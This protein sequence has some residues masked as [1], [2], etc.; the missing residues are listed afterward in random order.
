MTDLNE[1][2]STYHEGVSLTEQGKYTKALSLCNKVIKKEP[3]N[4]GALCTKSFVLF[5]L[6]KKQ[7]AKLFYEKALLTYPN[8]V[9]NFSI[10]DEGLDKI[11]I[12]SK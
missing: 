4:I 7:E 9:K 10:L 3:E 11:A 1:I 6:D 5:K 8:F 2:I 12:F